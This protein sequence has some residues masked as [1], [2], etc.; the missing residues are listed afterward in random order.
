MKR[1]TVYIDPE[2]ELLLKLESAKRNEP[3]A[4]LIREAVRAYFTSEADEPP[5]L[6]GFKS[7]RSE[8]AEDIDAALA[9][10][11]YSEG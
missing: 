11:G 9:E 3:M 6:G 4:E 10:T 5:G 7:G 1:T 8:T 2:L